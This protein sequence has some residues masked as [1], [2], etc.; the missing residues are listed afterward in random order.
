MI[1]MPGQKQQ[2][3]PEAD[4]SA[5]NV[6]IT[7]SS[8]GSALNNEKDTQS[9]LAACSAPSEG[10]QADEPL[11]GDAGTG[12]GVLADMDFN[13]PSGGDATDLH[14]QM[15]AQQREI[16]NMGIGEDF[17]S[18]SEGRDHIISILRS[19]PQL[20]TPKYLTGCW[21]S[22]LST[23]LFCLCPKALLICEIVRLDM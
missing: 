9:S 17:K 4:S 3:A 10:L 6:D 1:L 12:G 11:A 19:G 18:A 22:H 21:S 2:N 5:A 16:N 7:D 15:M 23:C 14:A 20:I 8:S 13:G